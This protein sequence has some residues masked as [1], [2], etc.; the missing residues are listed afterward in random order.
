MGWP[1]IE[2]PAAEIASV[3]AVRV[4]PFA[5]FGGWGYRFG[6][7]GRRGVVLRAGDALEVARTNG[8]VFVVTVD[9][10]ATA[11]SVLAL[12]ADPR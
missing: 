3:R 9:D 2:I 5:E 8:R 12:A 1:R 10:A 6:V 11:A 4:D 7:D